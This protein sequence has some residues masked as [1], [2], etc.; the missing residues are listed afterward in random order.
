[1]K[2]KY[3]IAII[4]GLLALLVGCSTKSPTSEVDYS[5]YGWITSPETRAS[6]RAHYAKD[7]RDPARA[8]KLSALME[9]TQPD[10][11]VD[12]ELYREL[13]E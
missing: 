8:K 12:H 13:S 9:A 11:S 7:S 5:L 10:G 2:N 6:T 4:A 3:I 1:M